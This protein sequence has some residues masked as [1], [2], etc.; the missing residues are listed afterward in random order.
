MDM[1]SVGGFSEELIGGLGPEG[2]AFRDLAIQAAEIA[3]A[4]I[5]RADMLAG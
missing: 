2:Q 1:V 3:N 5:P 4:Q